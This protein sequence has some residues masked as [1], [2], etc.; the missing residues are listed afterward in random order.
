MLRQLVPGDLEAITQICQVGMPHD[1]FFPE[2]VEE[3]TLGA[4]DYDPGLSLVDE[5][6]GCIRGFVQGVF[7]EA[8]GVPHGWIRLMVVH[9]S[10]RKQGVGSLLLQE[11][12]NRLRAKGARK[13]S[14][15]DSVA[16]Y[17]TPGVDFRYTEAYGFFEKHGY[18]RVRENMNLICDVRP[19][20]FDVS[21]DIDRLER[22]GFQIKRADSVD[23]ERVLKFLRAEFPAWVGEVLECYRNRPIS[24]YICYHQGE[25]VGFSAYEGNNRNTGW[26][27]PMGVLP[28]TRGRGIG[29]VLCQL[30]LG[31][32]ARQGHTQSIIPWVGPVRFYSKVCNSRIDRVFWVYEKELAR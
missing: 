11:I 7:G 22:E 26:F 6:S 24:L 31:D 9:P 28:M 19:G 27:G 2:L 3:K 18:Q 29:R 13:I 1:R 25:V 17:L 4:R 32:I 21:A 15:M 30:C 5:N 16:N 8:L 12:E 14:T 23:K 20:Q 10:F